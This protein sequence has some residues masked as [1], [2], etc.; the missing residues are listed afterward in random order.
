MNSSS[1]GYG[2]EF[3]SGYLDGR[4]QINPLYKTI[5]IATLLTYNPGTAAAGSAARFTADRQQL[6]PVV[7]QPEL[8]RSTTRSTACSRRTTG[9]FCLT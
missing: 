8:P 4:F 9:A 5:P 1:G 2:Q 6:Y 7:W 3:G